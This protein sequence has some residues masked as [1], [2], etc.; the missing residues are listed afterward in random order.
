MHG[1]WLLYVTFCTYENVYEINENSLPLPLL[2]EA[3]PYLLLPHSLDLYKGC[4]TKS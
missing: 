2:F 4:P 3:T 1:I